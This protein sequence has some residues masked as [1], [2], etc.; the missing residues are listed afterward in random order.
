[1]IDEL[2]KALAFDEHVRIYAVSVKN[3]ANTLGKRVHYYP[4]ALDAMSRLLSIGAMMGGMLKNDQTVTLRVTGDGQIGVMVVDANAKGEIRGYCQN[5]FCHFEYNDKRLDV[6]DTVGRSGDISVVKDLKMREPFIGTTPIVSGEI[7]ED[8]A[9]YFAKSEQVPS[10][11]SVGSIIN[12]ENLAD[13]AGGFII[14]LLPNTPDEVISILENTLKTLPPLS[15]L[16]T[17]AKDVEDIIHYLAKDAI[18]LSKTPI[19]F[20]CNCSKARFSKALKTLQVEDLVD[21]IE[22]DHG[23]KTTCQFCGKTYDFSEDELIQLK[24]E[25]EKEQ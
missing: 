1:M 23:A 4:S 25:R 3:A 12:E 16:L 11:V 15:K 8:F 19:R 5:P 13:V 9:Y 17:E 14:Q 6:K 20:H 24:K 10:A 22:K 7:G 21:M 18:V 2:V